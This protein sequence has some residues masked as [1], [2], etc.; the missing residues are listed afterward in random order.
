MAN[1]SIPRPDAQFHA[2]RNNLVTYVNAH[3][4]DLGVAADE[5]GGK[6]A[7]YMLRWVATAGEKGPWSS[8]GSA[9]RTTAIAAVPRAVWSARRTLRYFAEESA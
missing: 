5:D 6:T 7:H 4:A 9:V 2:W 8:A 1:D 3:L